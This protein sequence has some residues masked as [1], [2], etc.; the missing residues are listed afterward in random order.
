VD[1]S[2]RNGAVSLTNAAP[3]GQISINN[4]HGSVDL[5]VP[6]GAGFVVNAQTKNGDVENDFGL[7]QQGSDDRP[8]L[9]GTVGSG[10]P[11]VKIYT[12]DGDIT[13]RKTT[14][15]PLPPVAPTPMISV[16]PVSPRSPVPPVPMAKMPKLPK[17]PKVS[18]PPPPM[19]PNHDD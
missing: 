18:A 8:T 13:V 2:N 19:P 16:V 10:G 15:A 6:G 7:K 4:S 14:V 12:T 5:G 11:N 17:L 1:I 3:L 9:I